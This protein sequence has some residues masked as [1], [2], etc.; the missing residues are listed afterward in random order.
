MPEVSHLWRVVQEWLDQVQ[1]PPSQSKLAQA[2]GVERSA[3]SDWKYG[4]SRPTPEHLDGLVKLLEPTLGPP[5]RLRLVLALMHDLGYVVDE[6]VPRSEG[7]AL[8]RE[9][10]SPAELEEVRRERAEFNGLVPQ[11]A[12]RRKGPTRVQAAKARQDADAENPDT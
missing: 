6:Q 9:D 1:F 5:V 11:A 3:V 8:V 7:L 2:I 10:L 4:K 12:R